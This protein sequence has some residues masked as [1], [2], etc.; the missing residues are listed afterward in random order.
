MREANSQTT[1]DD[2]KKTRFTS[3]LTRIEEIAEEEMAN[4]ENESYSAN[5]MAQMNTLRQST[6]F[7]IPSDISRQ[8][9]EDKQMQDTCIHSMIMA[10][11]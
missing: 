7:S 11:I 3:L 5:V 9:I 10:S 2:E 6:S 4:T 1:S 8:F